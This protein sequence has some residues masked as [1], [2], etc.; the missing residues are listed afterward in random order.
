ML[1]AAPSATFETLFRDGYACS[2]LSPTF[3]R[4]CSQG[5]GSKTPGRSQILRFH[6][7][8]PR[9][10]HPRGRS[11]RLLH[12]QFA[13]MRSRRQNAPRA[14]RRISRAFRREVSRLALHSMLLVLHISPNALLAL[15]PVL[16]RPARNRPRTPN[17]PRILSSAAPCLRHFP[18]TLGRLL[19]MGEGN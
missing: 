6:A 1:R 10:L 18:R 14:L 4:T 16:A 19:Q 12:G 7:A 15:L 9:S 3:L 5:Q 2:S 13:P 11:Q 17:R 8:L